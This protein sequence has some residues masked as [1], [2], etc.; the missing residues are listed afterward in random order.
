[1]LGFGGLNQLPDEIGSDEMQMITDQLIGTVLNLTITNL[2]SSETASLD[3][4]INFPCKKQA[5]QLIQ[6]NGNP[7][8]RIINRGTSVSSDQARV[9]VTLTKGPFWW[10]K[11]WRF[12]EK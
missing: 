2:H 7:Y 12:S 10:S 5:E 1:M 6:A 11:V 8:N 3:D 4:N 9:S